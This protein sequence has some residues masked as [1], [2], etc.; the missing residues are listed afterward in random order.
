MLMASGSSTWQRRQSSWETRQ[1]SRLEEPQP[2]AAGSDEEEDTDEEGMSPEE[3]STEFFNLL[4]RFKM[5]G[6]L[7]AKHACILSFW[8]KAAGMTGDGASLALSPRTTG[9]NFSSHFD[10]VVGVHLDPSSFY[11]ITLPSYD[12]S[13]A[14]RC[15]VPHELVLPHEALGEELAQDPGILAKVR[16][17]KVHE[18]WGGLYKDH[19]VVKANPSMPVLPLGLYMDGVAFLRRDS[20]LGFWL[21]NLVS[22]RRHLLMVLRKR[23]QCRCGCRGWCTL[24]VAW[25][26][27]AWALG[28]LVAGVRPHVRHDKRPLEGNMAIQAGQP[29]G[30]LGAVLLVKGDWAEFSHT[31]GFPSWSTVEQPC[32][33]CFST[34]GPEGNWRQVSGHSPL[35]AAWP[36]KRLQD[37]KDACRRCEK[38][39]V[40]Y[41]QEQLQ[42]L[43][44][45]LFYDKRRS[46]AA[47]KGRALAQDVPALGLLK[48]WRLE[49]NEACP[50]PGQLEHMTLPPDGLRLTFWD[51]KAQTLTRHNNPM[52]SPRLGITPER[53]CTDELH[54]LHLGIFQVYILEVVWRMVGA[55]V[56]SVPA[57]DMDTLV[58]LVCLR[59]KAE[60]DQ[61]YTK[62][63]EAKPEV[64]VHKLPD[65]T[66]PRLTHV[67]F[68]PRVSAQTASVAD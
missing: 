34:G 56:Y 58:D 38:E 49:G 16:S 53:L 14:S 23:A 12:R 47:A 65:F 46:T 29:L 51:V 33:K 67:G 63:Q 6:V 31:L 60:L 54:G 21:I 62:E 66:E 32:F 68:D 8:A 17:G 35:A 39:V 37:Y 19:K 3:A 57:N 20:C 11:G 7:T 26:V 2:A 45:S 50:D 41:S 10:L 5:Q 48:G 59:I 9:G 40:I 55:N 25:T 18:E 64:P 28:I 44:G 42:L 24:H 43:L 61:W 4:V 13:T 27:L 22:R 1:Y 30:F 15:E 36:T 52:F